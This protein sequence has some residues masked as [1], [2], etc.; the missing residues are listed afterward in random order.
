LE[1]NNTITIE[2]LE[3]F[4][5][6]AFGGVSPNMA[7]G[8]MPSRPALLVRIKDT[9]GCYGWGEVWANFPP[10]ANI[11]KAHVIEDVV[12]P[13]LTGVSFVEPREVQTSLREALSTYFLH[14]GQ[15]R[16]FE[17]I[18]AGLD[19]ALWDL[20]LRKANLSFR[21]FFELPESSAPT[22][23]SSI[24]INDLETLIPQHADLGQNYFKIKIGFLS[25]GDRN[26]V[27][28]A[29][30]LFPNGARMM[31]DSNQSWNLAGA[32]EALGTLERYDPYFAE[33]PIPADAPLAEWEAQMP[34][35]K[36]CS[37]MLLNGVV[38][39]ALWIWQKRRLQTQSSGRTL[40][41]P[42]WARWQQYRSPLPLPAK[43]QGKLPVTFRFAKWT[44]IKTSCVR[45][46]AAAY[47]IS[48]TV[49]LH[50]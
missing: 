3:L 26:L 12:A 40:W 30:A 41:V 39:P 6:R 17:H 11:H 23:A 43:V 15:S 16:V 14:V 27:E 36:C 19:T 32:K 35:Y 42:Q 31:V 44:S 45:I 46:C 20:A 1:F 48:M 22:Y 5:V 49:P 37:P 10:R 18:I 7:L 9:D 21:R 50:W 34:V 13:K 47:W 29:S 24:N 25:D 33:E 2:A 8:A 28:R 4:P 38:S